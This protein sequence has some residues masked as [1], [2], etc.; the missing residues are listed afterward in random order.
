M[1]LS[2]STNIYFNRPGGCKAT[3]Q[4]SMKRC[5]AAGYRVMDLNFHDCT[6]FRLP[7]V[8]DE[9]RRWVDEIGV[10]AQELD[11]VF[12]QSHASFYNFCD[13]TYKHKEYM[14]QMVLRAIECAALLNIPYVVIHA[15]TDYGSAEFVKAS[16]QKNREYF[17]PL[18]DYAQKL[19]TSIVLENLWDMNIRP[20]RRYT[21]NAEE[22]VDLVDSFRSP[23]VGICYDT[24]HATLMAQSHEKSLK[25]IGSRLVATH[26]SDCLSV[27][28]DH[29]LPYDGMTDWDEVMATLQSI[30][31]TGDFTYE[32][33]RY[34]QNLPDELIHGALLR[35]I[36]VGNHLISLCQR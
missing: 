29:L 3:I 14:D 31:Y 32:I 21:A 5:A 26:I 4:E 2:T 22:L 34:T 7:F 8:T 27:E 6:T 13:E 30:G 23:S 33:H 24:D 18:I 15:G 25:L 35:S 1:R 28:C 10:L 11:I 17:L 16:K 36:E 12:S 9:Y 19:N 20:L